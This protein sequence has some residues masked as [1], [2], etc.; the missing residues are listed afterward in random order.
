[1]YFL[2][3]NKISFLRSFQQTL[4]LH[5]GGNL[6]VSSHLKN[7][8]QLLVG[9]SKRH[10][11]IVILHISCNKKPFMWFCTIIPTGKKEKEQKN[12]IHIGSNFILTHYFT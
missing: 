12:E 10:G 9:S 6:V 3:P 11:P 5:I 4:T 2:L 7:E 1:M 8:G